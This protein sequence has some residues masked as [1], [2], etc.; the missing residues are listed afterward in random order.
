MG[1]TQLWV[2]CYHDPAVVL[3]LPTMRRSFF[4][5]GDKVMSVGAKIEDTHLIKH[6]TS[7]SHFFS[8]S[9]G[10]GKLFICRTLETSSSL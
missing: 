8:V 9:Q 1:A 2:V 7:T 4:V 3:H 5:E 10:F 6:T